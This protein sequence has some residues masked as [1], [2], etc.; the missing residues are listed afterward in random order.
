[1]NYAKH[2]PRCPIKSVPY[3]PAVVF[4][5]A[6]DGRVGW[7]GTAGTTTANF[8]YYQRM[9]PFQWPGGEFAIDFKIIGTSVASQKMIVCG[10]EI[11]WAS[12]AGATPHQDPYMSI[13]SADATVSQYS[14][15]ANINF[16]GGTTI[17][18]D[19][20]AHRIQFCADANGSVVYVDGVI[21]AAASSNLACNDRSVQ[22]CLGG[23]I[24][25]WGGP[26]SANINSRMTNELQVQDIAIYDK[27]VFP[28]YPGTPFTPTPGP[29]DPFSPH[30]IAYWSC[31]GDRYF[32]NTA[33][34]WAR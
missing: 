27:N 16:K 4:T 8:V 30:M 17:I 18:T 26:T 7:Q 6:A 19:G 25:Q 28:T 23:F 1:M 33:G 14:S 29:I 24:N 10:S 9:K 2:Y 34:L 12:P 21:E 5:A 13:G 15:R 11:Y 31:N 22:L 3:G 20:V 32:N